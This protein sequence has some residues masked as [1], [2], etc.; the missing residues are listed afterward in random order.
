MP[1]KGS[2]AAALGWAFFWLFLI[3]NVPSELSLQKTS[4]YIGLAPVIASLGAL[5][6]TIASVFVAAHW[7]RAR[8]FGRVNILLA[9]WAE[10]QSDDPAASKSVQHSYPD[11]ETWTHE[12]YAF[13][14]NKQTEA[15]ANK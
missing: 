4:A 7:L 14:H 9:E 6:V 1:Y 12:N 3:I 10:Y 13:E 15:P 5:L 8:G 2:S 11:E